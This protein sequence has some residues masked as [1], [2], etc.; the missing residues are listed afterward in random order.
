MTSTASSTES[1]ARTAPDAGA[2]SVEPAAAPASAR[3]VALVGGAALAAVALALWAHYG[4]AVF[5]DA[6]GAV[7]S[8]F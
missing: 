6:L 8:C 4:S 2:P 3:R 7:V 5:V 1:D